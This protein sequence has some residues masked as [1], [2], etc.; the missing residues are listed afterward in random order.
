MAPSRR[1][2]AIAC[3]P[4]TPAPITNTRAGG[5]VPAAV[6]IIGKPRSKAAAPRSRRGSRPGWP[7]CDSTSMLCARVIR[8]SSSIAAHV[9]PGSGQAGTSSVSP[10]RRRRTAA[11]R[12]A[13]S[14]RADPG[15][16]SA[17]RSTI[18]APASAAAGVRRRSRRPALR[19]SASG[20]GG[21]PRRRPAS[22]AT[23][24]PIATSFLT[25]SGVAAT[26]VSAAARSFSTAR[27]MRRF[28]SFR[29][30]RCDGRLCARKGRSGNE[31]G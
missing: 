11:A 22:T 28:L 15:A 31:P 26:R 18:S 19:K 10:R 12:R 27:R 8:G 13:G 4:A 29:P 6:I 9:D 23:V 5:T 25:V 3:S 16:A 24:R 17:R 20:N 14:A 30:L 1:A 2:V 21:A 7:G